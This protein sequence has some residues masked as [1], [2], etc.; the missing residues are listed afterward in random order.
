MTPGKKAKS[1]GINGMIEM[2]Q[3]ANKA[4]S[5]LEGWYHTNP[6]LF[7]VV[8]SGCVVKKLNAAISKEV[9]K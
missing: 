6:E 4:K 1:A 3:L 9:G 8:L 7:N 5:T 2:G